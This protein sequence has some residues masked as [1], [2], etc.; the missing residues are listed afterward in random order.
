MHFNDTKSR[1]SIVEIDEYNRNQSFP[2]QTSVL[3]KNEKQFTF[4]NN[5]SNSSNNPNNNN[6]NNNNSNKKNVLNI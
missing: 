3:R 1:D 6:S 4:F 2:Y 5:N